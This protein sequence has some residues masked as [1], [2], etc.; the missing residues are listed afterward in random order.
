[1]DAGDKEET[2]GMDVT[3][4]TAWG[5]CGVGTAVG[6][7]DGNDKPHGMRSLSQLAESQYASGIV[8]C[9]ICGVRVP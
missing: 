4:G 2:G 3:A 1:M 9:R 6:L 7:D 8:Q 5:G